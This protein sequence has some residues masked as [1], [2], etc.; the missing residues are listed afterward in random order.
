VAAVLG[1]YD[2]HWLA[3][4]LD[5]GRVGENAESCVRQLANFAFPMKYVNFRFTYHCNIACRHCYNNS[6][7]HRKADRLSLETMLAIVAEMPAA[8]IKHLNLSGGEPFL[9]QDVLM[10]LIA[11]GRAA[12]L[13]RISIYTNGFWASTD[14]R[15]ARV[16]ERLAASGFMRSHRDHLKVSGGIYHQEFIAFERILIAARNYYSRF[17]QR[18]LVDFELPPQ[19]GD[20]EDEVRS[21]VSAAGLG[22]QIKLFFRAVGALGRG[23]DIEEIPKDLLDPLPCRVI[24]QIAFD[25]DGSVRPCCG[26]NNEHHGIIIGKAGQEHRLRNLAKRMQNDPILQL[27]GTKSMNE[28]FTYLPA[29]TKKNGY[30]GRCDMCMD[31]LGGLTDKEPLQAALFEQQKF[32]PFWFS[33]GAEQKHEKCVSPNRFETTAWS[34]I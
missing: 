8:G 12:G 27:I 18:L 6:G 30:G 17:G 14:E 19:A 7:P 15:A 9:Y 33:L 13:D 5:L 21:R 34:S 32:Y 26:V 23:K 10:A 29:A 20:L 2:W 4:W 22:E 24:N 31:A 25:P 3:D 16:L 1:L 11:A 28:I